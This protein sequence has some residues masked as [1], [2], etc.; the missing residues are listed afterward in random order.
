MP[1][2][3][4]KSNATAP[5]DKQ[6]P[7]SPRGEDEPT[8]RAAAPPSGHDGTVASFP[9][10]EGGPVPRGRR[11]RHDAAHAAALVAAGDAWSALLAVQATAGMAQIQVDFAALLGGR[12]AQELRQRL[13]QAQSAARAADD[14]L[15]Q[16]RQR[17][18]V[19]EQ[20]PTDQLT[21]AAAAYQQ[22]RHQLDAAEAA[23]HDVAQRCARPAAQVEARLA[24]VRAPLAPAREQLEAAQANRAAAAATGLVDGR[25]DELLAQGS[26]A[27]EQGR[28]AAVTLAGGAEVARLAGVAIGAA[29]EVTSRLE[30]L[31][32][33][34]EEVPHRLTAVRTRL[35]VIEGRLPAVES[36]LSQLRRRYAAAAF[37]DVDGA[38]RSVRELVQQAAERLADAQRL[39]GRQPVDHE[40]ALRTVEQVHAALARADVAG[41]GPLDRLRALDE[42][43]ADPSGSLAAARHRLREAQRFLLQQQPGSPDPQLVRRLDGLAERL[44]RAEAGLRGVHPDWWGYLST[45]NAVTA[46]AGRVV[47]DLRTAAARH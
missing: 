33:L 1:G 44:D 36:A 47:A 12:E 21:G 31:R 14:A 34:P 7:S 38:D 43:S 11:A 40:G 23:L 16:L 19:G 45:L 32:S 3:G 20:Y 6:G 4:G 25:V 5:G 37:S 24:A 41:R 10:G 17:M 46:D 15:A 26:A 2:R 30:L 39:L 27:W 42:I 28:L 29:H 9:G 22:V 8:V 35:Q 18:P 13:A